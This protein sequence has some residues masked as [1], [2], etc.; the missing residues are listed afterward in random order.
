M[1]RSFPAPTHALLALA[2]ALAAAPACAEES[3]EH[4]EAEVPAGW[5]GDGELGLAVARGNSRSESLNGALGL[6]WEDSEWKHEFSLAG[7]R[8]RGEVTGDFDGDGSDETRYAL[9]ANRYVLG[10]ATSLKM[11][12][13]S[14]WK[15]A[16]RYENDDFAA[17]DWQATVA[18]NYGI[19]LVDGDRGHFAIEAGPGYR[20]VRDAV[21]GEASGE[22]ITRGEMDALWQLTATTHLE[23]VLLVEAGSDNTFAQN[24][25]ALVVAMS[26]AL[27][28]KVGLQ[29]RHNTDV[30]PG[31]ANTDTLSTLN[32]VY[33]F[34]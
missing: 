33:R 24:D 16:M 13:R 3:F 18:L 19:R 30:A 15:T 2:L 28:L 34:R 26:D 11:T 21:L 5:S 20:R 7:L 10:G 8:T 23:D 9:T 22:F 14:Y 17:Y 29:T 4:E 31:R 25:L 6:A 12:E 1:S 32:L 27:A